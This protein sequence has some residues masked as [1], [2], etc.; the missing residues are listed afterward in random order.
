MAALTDTTS[1]ASGCEPSFTPS[2]SLLLLPAAAAGQ[3]KADELDGELLCLSR[4][5]M[6]CEAESE[7]LLLINED[8]PDV[9]RANDRLAA[10]LN[11]LCVLPSRTPEALRAKAS[12]LDFLL[13]HFAEDDDNDGNISP[14]PLAR[15]LVNDLLGRA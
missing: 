12:V 10:L 3:A 1:R 2:A 14:E 8:H 9:T 7:R 6:A 4:E 13:P 15:S 11:R 5:A